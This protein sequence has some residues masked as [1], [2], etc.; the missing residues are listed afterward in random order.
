[1][2]AALIR[3]ASSAIFSST[4]SAASVAPRAARHAG[5]AAA[6]AAISPR[7]AARGGP[8]AAA[9]A[10][11]APQRAFHAS[12]PARG[13]EEF[14]PTPLPEGTLPQRAGR[15]WR[16][17]ELR[18]KSFSD[19]HKLWFVCLKERNLLLTERLY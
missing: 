8:A 7:A 4:A 11:G 16:A 1:M 2:R 17:S 18:L 3:A 6:P 10:G 15:A 9:L 12:A 13:M 14:F 5:A 19:L